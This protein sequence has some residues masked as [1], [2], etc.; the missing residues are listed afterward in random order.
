M[1]RLIARKYGVPRRRKLP[2]EHKLVE[3][4]DGKPKSVVVP[5]DWYVQ[6]PGAGERIVKEA[7]SGR[8]A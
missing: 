6:Q 5:Y 3:A 4:G 2:S 1:V 7:A 8:E